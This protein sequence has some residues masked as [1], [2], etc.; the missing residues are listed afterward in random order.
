MTS[1]EQPSGYV[2][3]G[4]DCDDSDPASYPGADEVCDNVD[5][6]CDGFIPVCATCTKSSYDYATDNMECTVYGAGYEGWGCAEAVVPDED[7]NTSGIC[8][9]NGTGLLP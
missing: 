9:D 6:D 4:D 1:C 7:I 3:D 8:G 5:N 2:D